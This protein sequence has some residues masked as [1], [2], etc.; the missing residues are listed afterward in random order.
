MED[1]P[2]SN[3]REANYAAAPSIE[4]PTTVPANNQPGN[5]G[6][7]PAPGNT[8]SPRVNDPSKEQLNSFE[9]NNLSISDEQIIRIMQNS[10]PLVT[11]IMSEG[12]DLPLNT[13][14]DS[15]RRALQDLELAN[16]LDNSRL[17]NLG[18]Q[19][20]IPRDT[21]AIL[22][23]LYNRLRVEGDPMGE[24]RKY[25]ASHPDEENS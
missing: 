22:E 5:T 6:I 9:S 15:D 4:L 20:G 14:T 11:R 16:N 21:I 2:L 25:R 7:T 10:G 18:Q 13:I 23:R 24:V 17:E 12:P 1:K 19:A 3:N 8:N